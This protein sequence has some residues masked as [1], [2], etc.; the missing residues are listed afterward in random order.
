MVA[1]SRIDPK[2]DSR[3]YPF[4]KWLIDTFTLQFVLSHTKAAAYDL[5]GLEFHT[6]YSLYKYDIWASLCHTS[7]S[8]DSSPLVFLST[9]DTI[10]GLPVCENQEMLEIKLVRFMIEYTCLECVYRY[11][12]A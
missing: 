4:S 5:S 1:D 7:A 8:C 10:D 3:C 6:I 9:M 11:D 12:L 2:T